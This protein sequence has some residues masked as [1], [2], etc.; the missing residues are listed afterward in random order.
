MVLCEISKFYP[1]AYHITKIL[2]NF[3]VKYQCEW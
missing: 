2:A 3:A 1:V